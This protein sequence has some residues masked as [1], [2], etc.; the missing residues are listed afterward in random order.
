MFSQQEPFSGFDGY[1][2]QNM[3]AW[4]IPGL[5]VGVIKDGKIIFAKGYG[6]LEEGKPE[7][8]NEHSIFA[9]ASNSKAFT[10]TLMALLEQEKK[11]SLS[12]PVVKYLPDFLISDTSLTPLITITDLLTHRIG[13]KTFDGDFTMWATNYTSEQLTHKLRYVPLSYPFRSHWGYFNMGYVVCG[14]VIKKVTGSDWHSMVRTRILDPLGMHRTFSK[15]SE[16]EKISNVAKPH[17]YNPEHKVIP[18]PYKILD[19]IG[20]CG[21]L[22]SSVSDVCKWLAFQMDTAQKI[23]PRT[24]LRK[25]YVPQTIAGQFV[26]FGRNSAGNAHFSLYG[27]GW[28]IQ[29]FRGRVLIQHSGGADGMLS[30]SGFLP[31]E[32]LGIVVLTNY[33]NQ[34]FYDALFSTLIEAYLGN[35]KTDYSDPQLER[36]KK[37]EEKEKQAYKNQIAGLPANATVPTHLKTAMIGKYKHPH[38]GSAEI[39]LSGKDLILTLEG[40]PGATGKLVYLGKG[41]CLVTFSDPTL[42]WSEMPITV[43]NNKCVSFSLDVPDFVDTMIYTFTRD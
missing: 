32:N 28:F 42:R 14:E 15:V 25:T 41:S 13:Y 11:I 16:L 19:E 26:P 24:V 12:D 37:A 22:N 29:D 9:I 4:K 18:I 1:V 35:G 20:P 40:H 31:E 23:I 6:V 36:F 10:G 21:S 7:K 33:D 43:E 27:L 38:Y 2:E 5:A 17:T 3:K 30:K 34:N 39:K 8:V